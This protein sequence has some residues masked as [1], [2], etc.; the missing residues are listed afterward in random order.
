MELHRYRKNE[1]TIS[2]NSSIKHTHS[3]TQTL[4]ISSN[5]RKNQ[6]NKNKPL[7]LENFFFIFY[8]INVDYVIQLLYVSN[9]N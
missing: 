3:Q 2:M 5:N 7:S 9:L 8:L 1:E 4:N 6:K